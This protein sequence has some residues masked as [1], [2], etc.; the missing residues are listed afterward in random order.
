MSG[1]HLRLVA[2]RVPVKRGG[3]GGVNP[4]WV[5]FQFW[6]SPLRLGISGPLPKGEV[7]V[8]MRIRCPYCHSEQVVRCGK[9]DTGTQ[10]YR[11][12]NLGCSPTR[13]L[14]RSPGL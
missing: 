12:Q 13:S 1:E 2:V 10:R 6:T 3:R 14:K 4:G 7:A 5:V 11:C 9:T 8:H